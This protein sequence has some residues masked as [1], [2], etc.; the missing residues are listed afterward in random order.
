[1]SGLYR[2]MN[3]SS[4]KEPDFFKD[5][6]SQ[7]VFFP[8]S[9]RIHLALNL[10]RKEYIGLKTIC[11]E[12]TRRKQQICTVFSLFLIVFSVNLRE[13]TFTS[14]LRSYEHKRF[15]NILKTVQYQYCLDTGLI[16]MI[17]LFNFQYQ[18]QYSDYQLSSLLSSA[19]SFKSL[20][21]TKKSNVLICRL[22]LSSF[23]TTWALNSFQ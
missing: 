8:Q 9:N 10:I 13:N 1:M 6:P 19:L 5:L 7:T 18:I 4:H 16:S 11:K 3:D 20:H 2:V 23:N 21:Y 12:Q 17:Q 22:D 14:I 15:F